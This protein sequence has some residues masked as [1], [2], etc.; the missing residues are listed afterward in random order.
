[1]S[2][3]NHVR[4]TAL[5][6][7]DCESLAWLSHGTDACNGRLLYIVGVV[8]TYTYLGVVTPAETY[9]L[10]LSTGGVAYWL[11]QYHICIL[12]RLTFTVA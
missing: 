6:I 9:E 11:R 10:I 2:E 3:P 1:M 12:C 5:N 8:I 7:C 4:V